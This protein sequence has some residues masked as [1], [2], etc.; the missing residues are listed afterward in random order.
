MTVFRES[1]FFNCIFLLHFVVF[2]YM[3]TG[4]AWIWPS[5]RVFFCKEVQHSYSKT[6]QQTGERR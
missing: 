6:S 1:H 3:C 4:H 2:L 5:I